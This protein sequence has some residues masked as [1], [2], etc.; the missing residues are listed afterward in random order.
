METK[1]STKEII[2]KMKNE[3]H[4]HIP[5]AEYLN[6]MGRKTPVG[7]E[8]TQKSVS[9]YAIKWGVRSRR[10]R[11]D[12]G[13]SKTKKVQAPKTVMVSKPGDDL[14]ELVAEVAL[15]NISERLKAPIIR[16]IVRG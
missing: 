13:A 14:A 6:K 3:G 4:G 15:S 7:K 8:W 1:E 10:K 2:R 9:Y 5:I 12:Y 11:N 16:A